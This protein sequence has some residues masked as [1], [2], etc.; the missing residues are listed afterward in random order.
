VAGCEVASGKI[1]EII[2]LDGEKDQKVNSFS[3][4]PDEFF[5]DME[6][7]WKGRIKTT[8]V[9]DVLTSVDEAAEALHLAVTEDFTPIVSRIKASMSPLKAPK[10]EIS[11]SREQE[12]VWF[13]GKQFMPDVWTGSPGEEHIKQLKHA[14]DSKG[15]KVG[16]EWFTTAKVDTAL[17][18]YHEANAKAKSRVLELLRE[19]ATELQSHINIIVFSSTLLVITKALYAHVREKE[20]MGFSYNSRVPKA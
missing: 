6:S 3:G 1:G 8:H 13:K 10:G 17:S 12:A 2:S 19:L 9:N 11:Y 16:M 18:R 5:E 15:R 20:E 14:L 7:V 4:I